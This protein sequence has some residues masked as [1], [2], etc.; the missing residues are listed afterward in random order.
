MILS[1]EILEKE[2][3]VPVTN[4]SNLTIEDDIQLAPTRQQVINKFNTNLIIFEVEMGSRRILSINSNTST[5]IY[6]YIYADISRF[7][8]T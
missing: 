2:S 7:M 4:Y 5:Y 8:N 6:I 1:L 3:Y